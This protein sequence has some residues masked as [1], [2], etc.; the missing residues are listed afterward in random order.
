MENFY[1]AYT[2]TIEN[3]TYFFVKKYL[4]FPEF[5]EVAP[6]LE[7]YGMHTD[8]NKACGIAMITDPNIKEQLLN[9]AQGTVQQAKVIDLNTINF[10]GK[11]AIN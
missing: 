10:S 6:V 2:K 5:K 11:S 4:I 8:F 7:A 1:T 9:E 3:Q